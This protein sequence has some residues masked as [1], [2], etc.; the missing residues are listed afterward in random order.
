MRLFTQRTLWFLVIAQLLILS[1]VTRGQDDFEQWKRS[2][3]QKYKS[4]VEERDK[5]FVSFLKREWKQMQ[6]L[7][8]LTPDEKPKPV[9]IPVYAPP[10]ETRAPDT[11]RAAAR[12]VATPPPVRETPPPKI[13]KPSV[14]QQ[15]NQVS[16][17]IAFFG[18]SLALNYDEAFRVALGSPINNEAIGK[19]WESLSKANHRDLVK[20]VG[21]FKENLNLNDWGYLK[22]LY[23]IGKEIYR[24]ENDAILFTWFASSKSGYETRIGFSDNQVCLLIPT[25]NTLFNV[26]FFT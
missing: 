2:E 15:R 18:N 7:E 17:I 25:K 23:L 1:E 14:D 22:L 9:Q 24:T 10:P 12:I 3:E 5:E 19:F 16:A 8:G 20:Q 4:F 6:L 11:S 21:F 26:P 13:V